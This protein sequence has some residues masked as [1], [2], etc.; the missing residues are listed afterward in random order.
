MRHVRAAMARIA[1]MFTRHGAD[2]DLR[3]ELLSHLEMEPAEYIRRGMS[4][5]VARRKALVASGG[6]TIAAE[7]V[8]EQRGVP[9]LEH[10]A[11]ND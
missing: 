5:E 11:P 10:L 2:D 9:W 8:R 1:G 6:L 7:A 4:P 3:A